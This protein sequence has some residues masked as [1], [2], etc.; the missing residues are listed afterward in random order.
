MTTIFTLAIA[1]GVLCAAAA[2]LIARS[3]QGAS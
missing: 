3:Q 1:G 2:F